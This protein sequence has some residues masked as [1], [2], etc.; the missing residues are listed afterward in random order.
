MAGAVGE[1][2]GVTAFGMGAAAAIRVSF[3]A[4]VAVEAGSA[5][6]GSLPSEAG[7]GLDAWAAAFPDA[8]ALIRL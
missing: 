5:A 6:S 1:G 4:F 2:L 8:G 3:G 7:D